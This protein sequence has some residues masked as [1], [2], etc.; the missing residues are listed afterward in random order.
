[1]PAT[2]VS[3]AL[4]TLHDYSQDDLQTLRD[5]ASECRYLC[6][7]LEICPTT[8]RPHLHC[9]LQLHRKKSA[10]VLQKLCQPKAI[11]TKFPLRCTDP[12][13]PKFAPDYCKKG[14]QPHAEWEKDGRDGLH[15][16]D[17]ATFE[18]FG[19]FVP[20][21]RRTDLDLPRSTKDDY[22]N[23][24]AIEKLK[25]GIFFSGKYASGLKT[26][27]ENAHVVV[28]S[29]HEPDPGKWTSDRLFLIRLSEPDPV[30]HEAQFPLEENRP[31]F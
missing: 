12:T 27:D 31:F 15:F 21:G 17:N 2:Q 29:N 23:Y 30:N 18:E 25:D 6:F 14:D 22:I 11:D 3:A 9:V 19:E 7:G 24:G 4:L 20:C 28:F 8:N 1:M 13:N 26:R 10:T 5:F 16:G